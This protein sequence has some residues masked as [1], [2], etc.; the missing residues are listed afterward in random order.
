VPDQYLPVGLDA[1]LGFEYTELSPDRVVVTWQLT[2]D[3]HQPFGI[4]HGG[5]YCAV[6]ESAA[7]MGAACWLGDRGKVVGVANQTD[8][9]RAVGEGRLTAVASPVHRGRSQQLWGVEI[10]DDQQRLVARG[11]VRLQNLTTPAA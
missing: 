2:P 7:S 4:T 9:L 3:H 5:V 1:L 6:I 10:T 11:Q 8:F